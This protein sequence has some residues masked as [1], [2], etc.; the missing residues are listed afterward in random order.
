MG[1]GRR[2]MGRKTRIGRRTMNGEEE[3]EVGKDEEEEEEEKKEEVVN[4]E[5]GNRDEEKI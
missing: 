5:V 2:R 3:G 4:E 1:V